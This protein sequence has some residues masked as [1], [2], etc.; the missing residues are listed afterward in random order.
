MC[1]HETTDAYFQKVN[2]NFEPIEELR[3]VSG[4]RLTTIN[5]LSNELAIGYETNG[6]AFLQRYDLTLNKIEDEILLNED[7][8]NEYYDGCV[9]I[10]N[11]TRG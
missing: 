9:N 2:N 6:Q 8:N 3:S 4:N 11:I 5:C 7:I 1:L 10:S